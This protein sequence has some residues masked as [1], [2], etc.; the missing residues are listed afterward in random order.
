MR[1]NALLYIYE[2][3]ISESNKEYIKAKYEDVFLRK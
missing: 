3:I 1:K 2:T